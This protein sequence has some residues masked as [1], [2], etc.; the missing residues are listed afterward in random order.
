[1]VMNRS[2][3]TPYFV[4]CPECGHKITNLW[5]YGDALVVDTEIECQGCQAKLKVLSVEVIPEVTLETIR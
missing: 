4:K 3:G 5:E 1:M 2:H